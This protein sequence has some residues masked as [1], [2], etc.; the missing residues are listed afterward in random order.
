M[1]TLLNKFGTIAKK[2]PGMFNTFSRGLN[3]LSSFSKTPTGGLLGDILGEIP[4]VGKFVKK[5]IDLVQHASPA[6]SKVN[7]FSQ[8]ISHKG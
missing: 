6:V 8:F 3:N 1:A 2:S 5:G 7:D 4:I